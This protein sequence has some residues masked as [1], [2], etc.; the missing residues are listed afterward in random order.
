[1]TEPSTYNQLQG[2]RNARSW[3]RQFK[4][5]ALA[6]GVWDVYT[7]VYKPTVCPDYDDYGLSQAADAAQKASKS[8][9]DSGRDRDRGRATL[10]PE[11]VKAFISSAT[12]ATEETA[13]GLDFQGRM[14]LYKFTLDEY[15]RGRKITQTAMSLLIS[16]VHPTLRGQLE[17][18]EDP[19]AAYEYLVNRYDVS[20]ARAREIAENEFNAIYI[21]R[22]TT[23]QDYINAIENAKMDIIEAGGHCDEQMMISKLIRGLRGHPK[24]KEFATQYHLLR[25]IDIKFENVDHVITQ[26]LTYESNHLPDLDFR[27]SARPARGGFNY[28]Y[29]R[30]EPFRSNRAQRDRCIECGM[31]GH[32]EDSCWELHPELRPQRNRMAGQAYN[33]GYS[34][35]RNNRNNNRNGTNNS[36]RTKPNYMGA[37]T[38]VNKDFFEALQRAKEDTLTQEGMNTCI[39]FTDPI[40]DDCAQTS[41]R[42]RAV[43]Q[44]G[45][46]DGK[47][48]SHRKGEVLS[49]CTS[50][51]IVSSAMYKADT[52]VTTETTRSVPS[53]I[54]CVQIKDNQS[55]NTIV[56]EMEKTQEPESCVGYNSDSDK[57]SDD[58]KNHYYS[59]EDSALD[60]ELT[61]YSVDEDTD[62]ISD[63]ETTD[64]QYQVAEEDILTEEEWGRAFVGLPEYAMDQWDSAQREQW[65]RW[66]KEKWET[67]PTWLNPSNDDFDLH[68]ANDWLLTQ[69]TED[70]FLHQSLSGTNNKDESIVLMTAVESV[71]HKDDWILDSGA[72]IYVCNDETKF[73]ELYS[74]NTTVNTAS[75]S[76][77]MR[78]AGGGNVQLVL[79]DGDGDPFTLVLADVAYA[80][81]SRC[82]LMSISRLAK[83]GIHGSWSASHRRMELKSPGGFVIG[84][85][86]EQ[87]GLYR[88]DLVKDT[89]LPFVAN[90][91]GDKVWAEHRR[92]GHLDLQR[93]LTLC[94]RAEGLKVSKGEIKARIGQLCPIC[95]TTRAIVRI[96]REP[97]RTR[98]HEKGE[99]VHVDIWGPYPVKGWDGTRWCLFVTD[100]ATRSTQMLRLKSL[101]DWPEVLRTHHKQEERKYNIIIKRYRGDNQFN[102]D[103]WKSWCEK[104]GIVIESSA[105]YAHH[106]VGAAERV[107]RTVREGASA[108]WA[109]ATVGGQI[110][111]I[112]E[113]QGEQLRHTTTLPDSLWPE[114]MEYS[115]WLKRRT[116]TRANKLHKTPWELEQGRL[117]DLSRER[118][119]GSRVYVSYSEEERGRKLHDPRGWL[120]Y[121]VGC[122]NESTYRVW[123]P[124]KKIV[125]RVAYTTVDDGVGLNDNH[126]ETN[127][128]STLL[129]KTP[130]QANIKQSTDSDNA[131][132]DL[133]ENDDESGETVS[134]FFNKSAMMAERRRRR[135]AI[136]VND[137]D[138][139]LDGLLKED[140]M[141]GGWNEE[142]E[143][144]QSQSTGFHTPRTSEGSIAHNNEERQWNA[145]ST[146]TL[147]GAGRQS[148]SRNL[149]PQNVRFGLS[150]QTGARLEQSPNQKSEIRSVS[151]YMNPLQGELEDMDEQFGEFQSSILEPDMGNQP[152]ETVESE[153]EEPLHSY[154]NESIIPRRD[155]SHTYANQIQILETNHTVRTAQCKNPECIK[156]GQ[157]VPGETG[158]DGEILCRNCYR[159]YTASVKRNDTDPD[160]WRK[161]R[162][163]LDKG[164]K[165]ANPT[166]QTPN[167]AVRATQ[168]G[169][170]NE[171]LCQQCH[172]RFKRN[173][174][175]WK[176]PTRKKELTCGNPQCQSP[177]AAK[178]PGQLGPD[179]EVLCLNCYQRYKAY[180]NSKIYRE[181]D[182]WRVSGGGLSRK[183]IKWSKKASDTELNDTDSDS[184]PLKGKR[185]ESKR[186]SR[187]NARV[188]DRNKCQ[189]C[190]DYGHNCRRTGQG[191]CDQCKK[192]GRI[193]SPLQLGPNGEL[194]DKRRFA[195]TRVKDKEPTKRE[196]KCWNCYRRNKSCDV[197]LP[198]NPKN[199]CSSC[200]AT[201]GH[202]HSIEQHNR[203]QRTSPCLN[204]KNANKPNRCDRNSTCQECIISKHSRCTYESE[205]G[206]RRWTE[207]VNPVL[208][209]NRTSK[210]DENVDYYDE[211]Y[212][213]CISC[214][215][216]GRGCDAG[217]QGKPCARC[218]RKTTKQ[219]N[220]C[221]I[222][223]GPGQT[224][225]ILLH[226]YGLDENG[227]VVQLDEAGPIRRTAPSKKRQRQFEDTDEENSDDQDIYGEQSRARTRQKL[228]NAK[229]PNTFMTQMSKL[230]VTDHDLGSFLRQLY[231]A[232][233]MVTTAN[234][235]NMALRP[236]PQSYSEAMKSPDAQEWR[237]AIQA[238]YDSLL[239]NNTWEATTLPPGRKALTTK[240]VLKKK[241]G[242]K[243]ELLRYKA[244][245]VA[246]GFQQVE[247][248]DYSETYSGVVKAAT[249]RLL[250]AMVTMS[251]WTCH[252]L[253][254]TTAFLNGEVLE[255][256]YIHPPQGYPHP[257]KVLRLRRALY[258]LKQSPRMWYRKL[259]HWL[260]Q[261][262]WRSSAYDE[263]VFYNNTK[264]LILTVYVD[265]INIFGAFVEV[266][267]TFKSELAQAFKMT[268]AG[269]AAW[270][271]GLQLDW[272]DDGLHMHQG[273]F[274][275]QALARY[276]LIGTNTAT[277]PVDAT[278]K[279][280]KETE[281]TADP[282]FKTMYM[283]MVGSLN[284]LQSKTMWHLAYAVS[285]L[286]RFM[287]NP[288]QVHMDAVLQCYRYVAGCPTLG[289]F[290]AKLGSPQIQG[291]VDSDWAGD[292]DT[293]KSTTG[294]VFTLAGS[295]ISWCTQR[296]RTVASSSTEA[297][298][299]AASD[300]CKEAIWLKGFHNEIAEVMGRPI[301]SAIPL[302]IDNKSALKLTKNPE[303][304]G[305]TKHIN[306]RHHFIREC[307]D[308]GEIVPRWISGKENPADLFT[309]ALAKTAFHDGIQRLGGESDATTP[310]QANENF[311]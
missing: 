109:D 63:S 248:Y 183:G 182:S 178:S 276:S 138:F 230:N 255:E 155:P 185:D 241:L 105:P 148:R 18:F 119:W 285:L 160:K 157:F 193:C 251:G 135:K 269:K 59:E 70:Q 113:T 40:A 120:G 243:G 82:S 280:V 153:E 254:I 102:K 207:L 130:M 274:V 124:H 145:E 265:D 79:R 200:R 85:A 111:R 158:P 299:V 38:F 122:E 298:Y 67:G 143:T 121:F 277:V 194:P 196:D 20:D 110:R 106:Q 22:Y 13:K 174:E 5:A 206:T 45:H 114:A 295:P 184:E 62:S 53:E 103:P 137:E 64:T 190:F 7:G 163:K 24:Y 202:C 35:S 181:E 4:V 260:L 252:Q 310:A 118:T 287:S 177:N 84:T 129:H 258:G 219:S 233:A 175:N 19:Q 199:P 268:D 27:G 290:Y 86:S 245:M 144:P 227:E 76:A 104:K 264:A 168:R 292:S 46:V 197:Q 61:E 249:Y 173:Q 8:V 87:G 278:K 273:G 21:T 99:L 95:K 240:W 283:S 270:Y 11:D 65:F 142:T 229:L 239:E 150:T 186:G 305:R 210:Q 49:L 97:A 126:G 94:D 266:I 152:A 169:P 75:E 242:P 288:N 211:N 146:P 37:A 12:K 32:G 221:T 6:K 217:E 16:W 136:N 246:R 224:E 73:T 58:K 297:E 291:F 213:G 55:N 26:L 115:T 205:D 151:N 172:D 28:G 154:L 81:D 167:A 259:R 131:S 149:T 171:I 208:P 23:A 294:W 92:L 89:N 54:E 101:S 195:T 123:N 52:T 78:I 236:D 39:P 51:L 91:D 234:T 117:P 165:C 170:D 302:A 10:G 108:M 80:P 69:F 257:G 77:G 304:H 156:P 14:A 56:D 66:R 250:F 43:K 36:N 286:S 187:L 98:Y 232:S 275:Q 228:I 235:S 88:L 191:K 41:R 127:E 281:A 116:P 222:W 216:V 93:M 231:S 223:T 282:K 176:I 215:Q 9:E 244:R 311:V 303:F 125:Q 15:D 42:L 192:S 161:G 203:S 29:G 262:G 132:S 96:P 293:G 33:N 226:W 147:V 261:N 57:G 107:H 238:E 133:S 159:R 139:E 212:K 50:P 83:A 267:T 247:G 3:K 72:N 100:D 60:T 271:L 166:C 74:F 218:V 209:H 284:Y 141:P 225:S 204:C 309:K 71:V 272:R 300:A 48:D 25:D 44:G 189:N 308:R 68:R 31:W 90:V 179:G 164:T 263:C 162:I 188:S 34:G 140:G 201:N 214:Q 220:R 1:M 307:V 289:V 134:K 128:R 112:I 17:M 198:I 253:D 301:Q 279:L 180:M 47:Y 256:I 237:K 30:N 306:V 2:K 296:Q